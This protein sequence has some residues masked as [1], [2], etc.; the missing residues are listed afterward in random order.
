MRNTS[1]STPVSIYAL[2]PIVTRWNSIR[3]IGGRLCVTILP[4]L[5]V[6]CAS[7]PPPPP[8]DNALDIYDRID[9]RAHM[10]IDD[11]DRADS[12]ITLLKSI[13]T[14][15]KETADSFD[16]Y[17]KKFYALSRSYDTDRSEFDALIEQFERERAESARRVIAYSMEVRKFTTERE[18]NEIYSFVRE[19]LEKE[20]ARKAKGE[21]K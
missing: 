13:A 10:V 21:T 9:R 12:A 5:L 18:W 7:S 1:P 14:E 11:P 19:E 15:H 6:A 4:L 3:T 17:R 2:T 8:Q 20:A 16:E